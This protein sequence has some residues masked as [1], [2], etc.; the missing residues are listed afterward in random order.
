VSKIVRLQLRILVRGLLT[1]V[2]VSVIASGCATSSDTVPISSAEVSN[3]GGLSITID[4]PCP[5]GGAIDIEVDETT[6]RVEITA[7]WSDAQMIDC[8]GGA[9]ESDQRTTSIAL[10]TP[11]RRQADRGRI[12]RS[13]GTHHPPITA[14]MHPL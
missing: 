11:G 4:Q 12:H 14:H 13:R 3:A 1:L 10:S 6:E 2:A 8:D 5:D 9:K 7:M